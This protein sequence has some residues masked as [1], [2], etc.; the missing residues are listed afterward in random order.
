MNKDITNKEVLQ[1]V[2]DSLHDFPMFIGEFIR[3][4][5][6][7]TEP[8]TRLNY[9]QDIKNFF[10]FLIK[11][12]IQKDSLMDITLDDLNTLTVTDIEI[13]LEYLSLYN[14]NE[15]ELSNANSAKSRKLAAIR[16]LYK[17]FLRK[18]RLTNN[19]AGIIETPKIHEKPII[20]LNMDEITEMLSIVENGDKLTKGQKKYHAYTVSRDLALIT[21]F[22]GT[23]L[24]VSEL[25]NIDFDDIDFENDQLLVLRK[26]G[27]QDIVVFGEEVRYALLSY[28]TEREKM[29]PLEG[30][31]TAFFLSMQRRRMSVRSVELLVKKYASLAAPLKKISPHKLRSTFGTMLYEETGDIYLVAG[32]LGHKDVNT[33]RKHYAALDMEHK[34]KAA[35]V[36]KLRGSN[37]IQ[38][39][40]L[41]SSYQDENTEDK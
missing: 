9:L 5:A 12:R 7:I 40:P 6:N 39:P 1:R 3:G 37:N 15:R 31:E 30:H 33:T 13:Y 23:G 21:L 14:S 2:R 28:L 16:S 17:Y 22:L 20:R 11:E 34:R 24:R 38:P 25:V 36:I 29:I 19:P 18:N 35:D 41:T 32:V 10:N 4:I 8:L 27:N 26:G